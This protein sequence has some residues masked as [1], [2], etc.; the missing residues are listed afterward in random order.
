MVLSAC[1]ASPP[2]AADII[3][4]VQRQTLVLDGASGQHLLV[5]ANSPLVRAF[6]A[7]HP[8]NLVRLTPPSD[9]VVTL[10]NVSI[11]LSLGGL[12]PAPVPSPNV[13]EESRP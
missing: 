9:G 3:I 6:A 12:P 10:N 7:A 4:H 5:H 1:A 13:S 11:P 2:P 8:A